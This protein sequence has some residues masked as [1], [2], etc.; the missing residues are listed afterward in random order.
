MNIHVLV[1]AAGSGSRVGGNTR[2]QYLELG[3]QPVLVQTLLRLAVHPQI[4]AIHLIVPEPDVAFC[5][6]E[7]V[8]RY[9]LEKIGGVIPGGGGRQE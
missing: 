8:D 2:K 5:R 6:A 3:D 9:R 4:T 7:L 1:P